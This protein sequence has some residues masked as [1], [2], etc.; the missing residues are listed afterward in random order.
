MPLRM[1]GG[2]LIALH[3]NIDD[4]FIPGFLDTGGSRVFLDS[5]AYA[6]LCEHSPRIKALER[7]PAPHATVTCANAI[8]ARAAETE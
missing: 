1:T 4:F 8:T 2:N 5:R 6:A 7:K 3:V